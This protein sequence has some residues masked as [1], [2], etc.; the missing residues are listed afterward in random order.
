METD[1]KKLITDLLTAPTDGVT[2]LLPLKGHSGYN[3]CQICSIEGQYEAKGKK[4]AVCFVN[5]TDT[6]GVIVGLRAGDFQLL[7]LPGL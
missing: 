2:P 7:Y 5:L 6:E 1:M 3:S 4:G